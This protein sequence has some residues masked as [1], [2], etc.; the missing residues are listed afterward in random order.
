ML[1]GEIVCL[2]EDGKPQFRDLLFRRGEPRFVAFDLLRL[3]G[4]DLHYTPL[5]ERKAKL[6]G[7][8][9]QK[10]D[11]LLYCD[12]VLGEGE[13]LFELACQQDLEGIV[14]KRKY[15][16]YI[17]ERA[18]W[19]KILT[20]RIRSG[21]VAKSCSSESAAAIRSIR[22][23]MAVRWRVKLSRNVRT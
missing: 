6:R 3:N 7:I 16:P 8:V 20:L 13:G 4:E 2:D 21:S 14:A 5:I 19:L 18:R 11:R 22:S 12:H 1:D 23:G 9:P 15:D 10:N 17:A